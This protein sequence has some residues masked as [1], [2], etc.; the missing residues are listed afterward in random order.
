MWFE[1]ICIYCLY[2]AHLISGKSTSPTTQSQKP[3]NLSKTGSYRYSHSFLSIDFSTHT[4]EIFSSDCHFVRHRRDYCR[5]DDFLLFYAGKTTTARTRGVHTKVRA[6]GMNSMIVAITLENESTV[7]FGYGFEHYR[8]TETW[9]RS[10][11]K[12][13]IPNMND[14][15]GSKNNITFIHSVSK[16]C[17]PSR[18]HG[19]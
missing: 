10:L 12:I 15:E 3:F 18:I 19:F 2:E 8:Y 7:N 6:T 13:E 9:Y 14:K 11:D 1:S 16:I 17:I 5:H 4:N